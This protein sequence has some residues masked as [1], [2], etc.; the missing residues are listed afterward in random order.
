YVDMRRPGKS[1]NPTMLRQKKSAS[2]QTP[3]IDD[4]HARD[5]LTKAIEKLFRDR[6]R[7]AQ[8]KLRGLL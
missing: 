5:E 2:S 3:S 4:S 6:E 1:W 8:E 7:Q